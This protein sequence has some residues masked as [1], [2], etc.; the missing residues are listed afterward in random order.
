MTTRGDGGVR[1]RARAE[2]AGLSQAEGDRIA[3][4]VLEAVRHVGELVARQ[5]DR[6]VLEPTALRVPD[7]CW[8]AVFLAAPDVPEP[9]VPIA[10]GRPNLRLVQ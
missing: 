6:V 3:A 10:G 9:V 2:A 7:D 5:P 4:L 8:E 1:V